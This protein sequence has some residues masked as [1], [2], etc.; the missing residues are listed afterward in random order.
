MRKTKVFQFKRPE[1]TDR[2][3]LEDQNSNWEKTEKLFKGLRRRNRFNFL[4]IVGLIAYLFK[5]RKE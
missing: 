4:L 2:F 3:N 1:G 5:R